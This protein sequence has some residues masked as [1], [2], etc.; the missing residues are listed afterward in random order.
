MLKKLSMLI[1]LVCCLSCQMHRPDLQPPS[2]PFFQSLGIKFNFED[3]SQRQSGRILW[4]FDD[5]L[6]KLVFFTPLNQAGLE[7]DASGEA[8]ALINFLNKT[9]W[10]G[11]FRNLLDRLWGIEIGLAQLKPLLVK[12][13]IPQTE[14]DQQGIVASIEANVE[15]GTPKAI[16]LRHGAAILTLRIYKNE[17]YPGKIVLIDYSGRYRAADLESVLNDD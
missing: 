16:R 17:L 1:G 11:D 7:L 3:G 6:V 5:R 14:F 8:V 9:Y 10:R 4:R 13:L 15:T 2:G 12:G